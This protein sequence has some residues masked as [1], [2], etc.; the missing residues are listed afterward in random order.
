MKTLFA[1]LA[2]LFL[3]CGE[4]KEIKVRVTY[5]DGSI[6][7]F[8]TQQ[9]VGCDWPQTLKCVCTDCLVDTRCNVKKVE[10]LN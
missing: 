8:T 3:S 10:I 7:T 9:Y 5:F 2:I 1:L 6:E 4:R